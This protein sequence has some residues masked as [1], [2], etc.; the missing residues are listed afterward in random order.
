[1][2]YYNSCWAAQELRAGVRRPWMDYLHGRVASSAAPSGDQL[3]PVG[4]APASTPASAPVPAPT[5]SPMPRP[6]AYRPDAGLPLASLAHGLPPAADEAGAGGE[7][8]PCVEGPVTRLRRRASEFTRSSDI[9][10][11]DA[12]EPAGGRPGPSSERLRPRDSRRSSDAGCSGRRSSQEAPRRSEDRVGS[13]EGRR[14]S[15]E[16]RSSGA[17]RRSS[18][19]SKLEKAGARRDLVMRR[20]MAL[21]RAWRDTPGAGAEGPAAADAGAMHGPATDVEGEYSNSELETRVRVFRGQ[22]APPG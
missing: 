20:R 7:L 14:R 16:R 10:A 6:R 9:A 15:S 21:E 17:R 11:R 3:V 2:A 19:G 8:A 13:R 22:T 18:G 1:M 5:P 4:S 12:P